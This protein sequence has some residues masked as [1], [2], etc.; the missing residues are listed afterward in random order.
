MDHVEQLRLYLPYYWVPL[1]AV[2]QIV[3]V[4]FSL[5]GHGTFFKH[6]GANLTPTEH[7]L[8]E[9]ILNDAD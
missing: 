6:S 9:I 1:P 8:P 4:F 7:T 3:A 2:I 5:V